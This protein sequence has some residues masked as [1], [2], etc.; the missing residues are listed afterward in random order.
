M[1][2]EHG[3]KFRLFGCE[4]V[5]AF[6]YD[7]VFIGGY[8]IV[9]VLVVFGTPVVIQLVSRDRVGLHLRHAVTARVAVGGGGC[10]LVVHVAVVRGCNASAAHAAR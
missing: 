4:P 10:V 7:V 1:R 8:A 2:R 9:S 3:Q 6:A 5:D